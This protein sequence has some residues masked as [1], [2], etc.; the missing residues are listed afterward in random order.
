MAAVKVI[1][2]PQVTEV[3]LL[4]ERLIR[5][6]FTGTKAFT[7]LSTGF[8]PR[9]AEGRERLPL[10]NRVHRLRTWPIR[11]PSRWPLMSPPTQEMTIVRPPPGK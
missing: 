1:R 10:I 6:G 11:V 3:T 4:A 8:T 9:S 2:T 7:K 5:V